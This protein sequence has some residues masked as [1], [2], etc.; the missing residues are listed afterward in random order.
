[1]VFFS[2]FLIFIMASRDFEI[3]VEMLGVILIIPILFC[4]IFLPF[5]IYSG[6]KLRYLLKNY[7]NF[8]LFEV[9]LD[10]ISVGLRGAVS[11]YVNFSYEG[12]RKSIPTSSCFSGFMSDFSV[13]EYNNKKVIILYDQKK[14]NVYVIRKVEESY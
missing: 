14:E 4:S 8:K 13:E 10:D 2:S 5:V 3:F 11:Y 1:M 6:Y 12:K 9:K 7:K